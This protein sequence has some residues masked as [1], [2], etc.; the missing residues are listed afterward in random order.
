MKLNL[1]NKKVFVSG[2][3]KGIGFG[4]AKKF[5]EEGSHVVLNARNKNELNARASLFDNCH[6]VVGDVTNPHEAEIIIRKTSEILGGID[7]IVCNVG[8][9]S[10][11][12]AGSENYNEW[13][14]VFGVNFF[15]ATNLIESSLHHL[16]K[17]KGSIICISSICGNENIAGA[18]VT[19]SVAKSALNTYVK[20]ISIPLAKDGIRINSVAPGNINFKGSIWEKKLIEDPAFVKKMLKDNVPLRK[21]GLPI[22]VA[23]T[24]VWL[25]SD[26]ANFVTGTTV[27]IDGGQSRS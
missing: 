1:K 4:I 8:S 24:V 21:L 15:S 18:P 22:D 2:S 26:V 17:T 23:N 19:Y 12:A 16:K 9:G 10:S 14:R 6:Y 27:T 20:A 13:Q 25:A 5:L 7:I 3:S 11:V